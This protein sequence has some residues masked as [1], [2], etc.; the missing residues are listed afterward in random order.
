MTV[1]SIHVDE[2]APNSLF[3][4]VT[5]SDLLPDLTAVTAVAIDVLK[6]VSGR[7]TEVHWTAIRSLQTA[8]T[9]RATHVF[10]TGDLDVS[11]TYSFVVLMTLPSGTVRTLPGRFVVKGKYD[12]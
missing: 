9:L 8:T 4:D 5:P 6:P 11:G 10:V 3:V 1:P 12:L 7:M 2:V